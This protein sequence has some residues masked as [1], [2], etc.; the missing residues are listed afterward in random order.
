MHEYCCVVVGNKTDTGDNRLVG[1]S[2]ALEFIDE[3]V[4]T[5]SKLSSPSPPQQ[6]VII[7]Q[8]SFPWDTPY[9][10]PRRRSDY[11]AMA[12]QVDKSPKH[13][14]GTPLSTPSSPSY[15]DTMSTTHTSLTLYHTPSSSIYE[16]ARSSPEPPPSWSR[17][18][19]PRQR[20]LLGLSSSSSSSGGSASTSSV[21]TITPSLFAREHT[22]Q[23]ATLSSSAEGDLPSFGS[24]PEPE[25][26]P[27]L[28]FTSAKTGEGVEDV[29]GYVVKRVVGRWEYEEAMVR[30]RESSC[31]HANEAIQLGVR[32]GVGGGGAEDGQGWSA[33]CA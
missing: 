30:F 24:P 27:K 22:S 10:M 4:P 12:S 13:R 7:P 5:V 11:I 32:D 8:I 33:C 18:T 31:Q 28:F 19:S 1:E 9:K 6:H 29:F 20:R 14:R 15:T 2:D 23:T 3:L 25:R 21:A 17:S 16:S 26:G